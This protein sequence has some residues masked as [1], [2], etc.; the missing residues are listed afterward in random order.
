MALTQHRPHCALAGRRYGAFSD[1]TPS[2]TSSHPVGIIIQHRPLSALAGKRYGSFAGKTSGAGGP[3]YTLTADH[4]T[5]SFTGSSALR[6]FAISAEPG[7]FS[8]TGQDATLTPGDSAPTYTLAADHGTFS[9]TGQTAGSARTYRLNA[10]AGV[11]RF[12]G[13]AATL[14]YSGAPPVSVTKP[15]RQT[16]NYIVQGKR[17]YNLTNEELAY[18]L[19]WDMI[20]AQRTDVKVTFKNK[21]PHAVSKNAWQTLQETIKSLELNSTPFDDDEESAMLL[22]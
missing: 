11:F 14:N 7:V 13:Q 22:L 19:A 9:F 6:G 10:D 20:D 16:R 12:Y 17:Y 4:G 1:K 8:F 21:K 2:P 15:G 5:F 3:T 18:L